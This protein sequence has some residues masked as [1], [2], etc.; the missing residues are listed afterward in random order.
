MLVEKGIIEEKP[1][2]IITCIDNG[3]GID[4]IEL[5]MTDGY[6]S[7]GGMG[8]GLPGAKRLVDRFEIYSVLN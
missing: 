6:T 3:P 8:Y 5:A 7:G 1:T 4:N 2:L